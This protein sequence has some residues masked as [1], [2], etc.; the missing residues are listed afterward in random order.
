M[1]TDAIFRGVVAP[2]IE[3]KGSAGN[4]I[5]GKII[6]DSPCRF[7]VLQ[8]GF[9]SFPYQQAKESCKY[10]YSIERNGDFVVHYSY[11]QLPLKPYLGLLAV[12]EDGTA[13]DLINYK[14]P[15]EYYREFLVMF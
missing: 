9:D 12:T 13:Y 2:K 8:H 10:I 11:D 15:K 6:S 4:M 14:I 1:G 3:V 7:Y 5:Y